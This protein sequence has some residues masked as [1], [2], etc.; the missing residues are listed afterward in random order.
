MPAI[1]LTK[2]AIDSLQPRSADAVYWDSTLPGFG[3]KVTPKGRKVFIALYRTQGGKSRLRKYTIG[4]LG[5][6]TLHQARIAAQR[7]FAARLEGRDPAA[8]KLE[9]RRREVVDR[10]DDVVEAFIADHVSKLRSSGELSRL[11]QRELILRWGARSVHDIKRRDVSDL[12]FGAS[13]ERSD[14]SAHKLLKTIKR[15]FSWCVGRAI[16]ESSPATG[17][18]SPLKATSRAR[19]LTDEELG[20]IV[21]GARQ[22]GGVYGAIVEFLIL[23]GQRREEVARMTWD[24]LDPD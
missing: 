6:I 5:R 17:V 11:L 16:M 20:R 7:I 1:K 19:I 4:P 8:E 15:F 21:R 18:K 3:V 12:V 9:L 23:T 13:V 24:E 10:I 2:S 22:I 14:H